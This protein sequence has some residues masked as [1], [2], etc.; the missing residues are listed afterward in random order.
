MSDGEQSERVELGASETQIL[1]ETNS[2]Q[3]LN[4][5]VQ[6]RDVFSLITFFLLYLGV[7]ELC[8]IT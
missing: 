6:K 8:A 4:K 1:L 5:V 2:L 7:K 3:Q